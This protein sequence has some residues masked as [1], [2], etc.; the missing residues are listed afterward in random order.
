MARELLLATHVGD[1]TLS[2][3]DGAP[4]RLVVPWARG[5]Q[6]VKWVQRV[7]LLDHPDYGA[8]ASTVWSGFTAAG[9]GG[10]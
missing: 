8:P 10:G 3:E 4:V 2:H 9:S 5:F 6:W 7:E 1:E